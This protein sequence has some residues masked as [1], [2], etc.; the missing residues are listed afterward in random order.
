MEIFI[1]ARMAMAK[2]TIRA[3]DF[4]FRM[5]TDEYIK[6]HELFI[7][8]GLTETAV[9]QITQYGRLPRVEQRL[10]DYMNTAPYWDIQLHG[11]AHDEY[12]KMSYEEIVRDLSAAFL[13]FQSMFKKYPTVWYT[14]WNRRSPDMDKAANLMGMTISNESWDIARF[15][16]EKDTFDGSTVYFHL[17]NK[18]EREKI[19]ETL[20]IIRE[21]EDR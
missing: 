13:H 15:I 7:E 9:V 5:G 19:P 18:N 10:I 21:M 3:D 17:W 1:S 8:H 16:R 12:D 6:N 2:I 20:K 14:P 4:D 11:W